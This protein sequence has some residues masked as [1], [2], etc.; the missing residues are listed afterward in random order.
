MTRGETSVFLSLFT[1]YFLKHNIK[2]FRL[3]IS[4]LIT[5]IFLA[6]SDI[7]EYLSTFPGSPCTLALILYK[8]CISVSQ[9]SFAPKSRY[10]HQTVK[11]LPAAWETE[12]RSLGWEGPLEK[13]IMAIHSSILAWRILWTRRAWRA[14][15]HCVT[16]SRTQLSD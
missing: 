13:G 12:F 11:N 16:D 9:A 7:W 2:I 14:T 10:A 8:H 5:W 1:K 6:T 15:V 4:P 3:K